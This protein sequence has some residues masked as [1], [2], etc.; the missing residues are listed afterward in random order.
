MYI[1]RN[2][3]LYRLKKIEELLDIETDDYMEYLDLLNCVLVKRF[4]FI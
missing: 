3:L 4:M 2:S 1:H